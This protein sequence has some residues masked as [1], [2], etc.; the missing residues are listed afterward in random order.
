MAEF[1]PNKDPQKELLVQLETEVRK[2]KPIDQVFEYCNAIGDPIITK[3]QPNTWT[4]RYDYPNSNTIELGTKPIPEAILKE[5]FY[6]ENKFSDQ[7]TL[8]HRYIHELAHAIDFQILM[9]DLDIDEKRFSLRNFILTKNREK[10][11]ITAYGAC[12][13]HENVLNRAD[14]EI[15]E[16]F[17]ILLYDEQYFDA[18][19][20]MLQESHEFKKDLG[21][22]TL[23]SEEAQQLKVDLKHMLKYISDLDLSKLEKLKPNPEKSAPIM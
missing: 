13:I 12:D 8:I 3:L 10:Q 6:L 7:D 23:T 16:I 14:E 22:V 20:K 18:Y 21:L 5:R 1:N 17:A 9:K 19:I 11:H 4:A 15:A 2:R